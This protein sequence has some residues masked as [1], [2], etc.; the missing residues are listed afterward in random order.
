MDR[1][2][3][4]KI[5]EWYYVLAVLGYVLTLVISQM[6]PGVFGALLM[7]LV[8]AELAVG[9][10]IGMNCPTDWIAAAFFA[11]QVLSVIW[12]V[13]GG[14]PVSV[15]ANELVSSTLPMIFYFVGKG[16]GKRRGRWYRMYIYALMILGMLGLLFYIWA[17]QFYLDWALDWNYISKADAST[18]RVRMQSVVGSTCLSFLMVTGMLAGS[19]FLS[20]HPEEELPKAEFSG[21]RRYVFA[22]VSMALCFLFAIMANQRSGLVA[23]ALV[24]IYVNYLLFFKLHI[25]PKKYFRYELAAIVVLF[26]AV[27]AIKFDFVLKFWYRIISL[28]TAISERSEQWVAAVNNMYSFWIGNGLGANG[29]RALGIEHAHVIADGGLI[30]LYCENGI[31]GFSL[32]LYLMYL[33]LSKGVKGIRENYAQVGI[34]AVGILQSIGS[35]MLAFQIC[36]PVFWF[37]AGSLACAAKGADK[38]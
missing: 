13:A 25:I 21:N 3:K 8:I 10:K 26:A 19:Y 14:Y 28:P 22:T 7:V 38:A 27:C 15:Y 29:H 20:E 17:P 11:Y 2:R 30:K 12:L 33:L 4:F 23:A 34:L 24:L 1:I 16:A 35:N 18:M 32:W 6:R 37:A 9:K 31:F 36:A 5:S